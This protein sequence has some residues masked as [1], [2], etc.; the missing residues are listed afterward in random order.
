[1]PGFG[2]TGRAKVRVGV[3]AQL[4]YFRFV[5]RMGV[6]QPTSCPTRSRVSE[7]KPKRQTDFVRLALPSFSGGLILGNFF[8]AAGLGG[9]NLVRARSFFQKRGPVEHHGDGQR[10]LLHLR[11][12]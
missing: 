4:D 5:D 3:F 8:L 2:M 6:I 9:G 11:R 10:G 12:A 7:R 1:M